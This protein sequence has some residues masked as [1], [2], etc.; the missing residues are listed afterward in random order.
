MKDVTP[1]ENARTLPLSAGKLSLTCSVLWQKLWPLLLGPLAASL[2][3]AE[4]PAGEVSH[5]ESPPA[6]RCTRTW[7]AW[8]RGDPSAP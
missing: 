3:V 5:P 6:D 2:S 8:C 7:S 1:I 4:V